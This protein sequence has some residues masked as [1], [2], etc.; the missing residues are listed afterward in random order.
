[1]LKILQD[2]GAD[3]ITTIIMNYNVGAFC[4]KKINKIW[5]LTTMCSPTTNDEHIRLIIYCSGIR[6]Y[7]NNFIFMHDFVYETVQAFFKF[8]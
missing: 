8:P 5:A 3:L 7:L 2:P 6:T 4:S 1:M